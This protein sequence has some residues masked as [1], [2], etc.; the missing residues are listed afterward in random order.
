MQFFPLQLQ[1]KEYEEKIGKMEKELNSQN[2]EI[3]DLKE[4]V[5][6]LMGKFES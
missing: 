2:V 5:E 4:K 6:G 1:V 3:K